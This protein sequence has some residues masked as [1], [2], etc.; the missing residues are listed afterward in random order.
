MV[1][2]SCSSAWLL[3]LF[4]RTRELMAST[5]NLNS[6]GKQLDAFVWFVQSFE[7]FLDGALHSSLSDNPKNEQREKNASTMTRRTILTR[8]SKMNVQPGEKSSAKMKFQRRRLGT[9]RIEIENRQKSTR[10]RNFRMRACL[11]LFA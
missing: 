4:T 8:T 3:V 7:Y 2:Q 10:W 1:F 6:L 11:V 9:N 5:H